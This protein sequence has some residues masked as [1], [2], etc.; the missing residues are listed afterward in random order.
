MNKEAFRFRSIKIVAPLYRF[1][2]R[3]SSQII[4]VNSILWLLITSLFIISGR[5]FTLTKALYKARRG[6]SERPLRC[7]EYGNIY[8]VMIRA[9]NIPDT[10]TRHVC[11][12]AARTCDVKKVAVQLFLHRHLYQTPIRSAYYIMQMG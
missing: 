11:V 4:Q 2:S 1:V 8:A 5:G 9:T 6:R 3:S 12:R 7:A 10:C